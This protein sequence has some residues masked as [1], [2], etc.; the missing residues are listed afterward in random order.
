LKSLVT[1]LR[2]YGHNTVHMLTYG[3]CLCRDM[4][5]TLAPTND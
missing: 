4:C 1:A 2:L 3:R 5:T